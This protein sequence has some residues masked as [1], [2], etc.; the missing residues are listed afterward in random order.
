LSLV[1]FYELS[2]ALGVEVVD[3][4]FE[5]DAGQAFWVG[6]IPY[7]YYSSLLPGPEQVI[8][9]Y[10]ELAHILYHPPRPEV[11]KRTGDLWNWSKCDRQAEIVGVVAWMPE[12][13]GSVEQLMAEFG[14]GR[15][16]AEF[17]HSLY[18]WPVD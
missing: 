1:D 10:H 5:Q 4:P 12:S 7:V 11:F 17:R 3:Y 16:V 9:C 15:E 18:L 13:K 8:T 6:D 2:E 14:V